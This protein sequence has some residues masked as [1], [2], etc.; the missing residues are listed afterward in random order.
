MPVAMMSETNDWFEAQALAD[1]DTP[2]T[3]RSA[4]VSYHM[5]GDILQY[6]ERDAEACTWYRRTADAWQRIDQQFGL[7]DFD[8][9]QPE[10]LAELIASDC[11]N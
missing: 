1:P 7:S 9:G 5:M 4:A 11:S 8:K 3:R 10:Y 2:G 6:A